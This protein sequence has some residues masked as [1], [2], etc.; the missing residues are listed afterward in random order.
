M[1][2][3]IIM[4]IYILSLLL[5]LSLYDIMIITIF[6]IVIIIIIIIWY[7]EILYIIYMVNSH[8]GLF[9]RADAA[10]RLSMDLE[11]TGRRVSRGVG[12]HRSPRTMFFNT[13]NYL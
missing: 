5:L 8:N 7:F 4:Y 10:R 9:F 1:I 2:I 6:I 3:I 12:G 13:Y 11:E